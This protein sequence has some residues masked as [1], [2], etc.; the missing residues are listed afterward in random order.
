MSRNSN[1]TIRNHF[2]VPTLTP[3]LV[4]K[5]AEHMQL[6]TVNYDNLAQIHATHE[7]TEPTVLTDYPAVFDG[8]M[9]TLPGVVHLHIDDTIQPVSSRPR[10]IPITLEKEVS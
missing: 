6:I 8:G 7:F 4:R 1:F 5:A 3:L 9:G 2:G 10:R